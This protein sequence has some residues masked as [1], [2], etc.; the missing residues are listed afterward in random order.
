MR[1]T[2]RALFPGARSVDCARDH[3]CVCLGQ[4]CNL[5]VSSGVEISPRYLACPNCDALFLEPVVH[6]N[7]RVICPRCATKLFARRRNFVHRATALVF[8]ASF[9]F[10]L[11]N[12]FPF[13]TL[14]ADYRESEMVLAGAVSGLQAEGFSALATMV[15]IF[16]LAAPTVLIATLL[17]VLVPLLRERRLPWAL[18]LCRAIHEARRWNMVEVFL[19]GVLVS[20][21]KLGT[22]ATLTLGTS[23]WAF[24]GLIVCLAAALA[25]IDQAELWEKLEAAHP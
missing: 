1:G 2:A 19:L 18:H 20:L 10:V 13:L 25:T 16:T 24:A 3:A 9:F 17:Y 12:A 22:V 4:S 8:A 5:N 11:A 15:A 21:L 23:F 14:Q 6:E 7:E